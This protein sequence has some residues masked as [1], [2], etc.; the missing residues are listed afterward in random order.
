MVSNGM[1]AP[2]SPAFDS[3]RGI[4]FWLIALVLGILWLALWH[5]GILGYWVHLLLVLAVLMGGLGV[6]KA[7]RGAMNIDADHADIPK[8]D[9]A[10]PATSLQEIHTYVI[11]QAVRSTDWYFKHKGAKA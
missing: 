2:S 8:W 10:S 9:P 3:K 5:Y 7:L 1:T 11:R 4:V 6:H